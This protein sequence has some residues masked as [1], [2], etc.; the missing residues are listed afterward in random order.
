MG[1]GN[2]WQRNL[3]MKVHN[4]VITGRDIDRLKAAQEEIGDQCT[5]ISNGCEKC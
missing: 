5:S 1:W 3:P 2:T 4:V